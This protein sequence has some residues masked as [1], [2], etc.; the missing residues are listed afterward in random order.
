MENAENR[1]IASRRLR[2]LNFRRSRASDLKPNIAKENPISRKR[3]AICANAR[4]KPTNL[5]T[6]K[7]ALKP[8]FGK[9]RLNISTLL[10][11][12]LSYFA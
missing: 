8:L 12:R 3:M 1:F 4:Q 2:P 11:Q 9:M 10:R 6:Q 7:G 5:K